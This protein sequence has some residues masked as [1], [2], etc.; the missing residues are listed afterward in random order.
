MEPLRRVADCI[1]F[2]LEVKGSAAYPCIIWE[3]AEGFD[4]G[5]CGEPPAELMDR[6]ITVAGTPL[7]LQRTDGRLRMV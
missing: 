4:I 5:W 1:L 7:G 2:H 3:C 6:P